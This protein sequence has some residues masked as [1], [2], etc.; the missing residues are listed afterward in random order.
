VRLTDGSTLGGFVTAATFDAAIDA[1]GQPASFPTGDLARV[2]LAAEPAEVDD[3]AVPVLRTT[4]GDALVGTLAGTLK[5]DTAFDTIPLAADQLRGIARAGGGAD[6]SAAATARTGA[7]DVQV[8]TWDGGTLSGRLQDPLLDVRLTSGVAVRVPVSVLSS[9]SQ[10]A[11]QPS[12]QMLERI[13]AVVAELSADDWKQRDR[14]EAQLMAMGPSVAGVLRQMR[15]GL[16][17]EPQQRIDAVLKQ[18][19]KNK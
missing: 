3:A 2:A 10:P 4:T 7:S 6:A 14:A 15:G 9:Y 11:P 17:A 13:R 16:A 1:T 19:E 5:L 12:G 8:T 18:F